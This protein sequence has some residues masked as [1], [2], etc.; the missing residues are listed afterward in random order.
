MQR[1]DVPAVSWDLMLATLPRTH[2]L[3]LVCQ[4][5]ISLCAPVVCGQV[6]AL[7]G[8]LLEFSEAA[9][10]TKR[11]MINFRSRGLNANAKGKQDGTLAFRFL[12]SSGYPASASRA[13]SPTGNVNRQVS[14]RFLMHTALSFKCLFG[15]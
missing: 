7:S 1:R 5:A 2:G 13:S 9:E 12:S 14:R 10:G 11:R 8:L 4:L 15:T 3:V 6:R